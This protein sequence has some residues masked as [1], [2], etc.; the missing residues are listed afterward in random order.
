MTTHEAEKAAAI[1]IVFSDDGQHIR[2]WSR[3]PF[4]GGQAFRALPAEKPRD[5]PLAPLEVP[6]PVTIHDLPAGVAANVDERRY[7]TPT[8]PIRVLQL[9]EAGQ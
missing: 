8:W 2:K 4:E 5:P 1:Y 9:K 7:G 3:E 6:N